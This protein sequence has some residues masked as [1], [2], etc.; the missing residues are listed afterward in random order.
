VI[1]D[2]SLISFSGLVPVTARYVRRTYSSFAGGSALVAVG[3]CYATG[4]TE[5]KVVS[6]DEQ[7]NPLAQRTA[8]QSPTVDV[9]ESRGYISSTLPE[10]AN[11]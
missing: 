9:T 5:A 7:S 3:D 11:V 8:G 1:A 10:K 4:E 2:P 6:V